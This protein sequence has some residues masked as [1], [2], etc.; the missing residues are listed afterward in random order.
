[1]A[2]VV[3]YELLLTR[4]TEGI[5]QEFYRNKLNYFSKLQNN[6]L[7]NKTSFLQRINHTFEIT[8]API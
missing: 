7:E 4:R 5:T 6:N 2:N 1:M 3:V 8:I